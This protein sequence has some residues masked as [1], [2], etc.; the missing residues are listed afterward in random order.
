MGRSG[1]GDPI[2]LM[3]TDEFDLVCA[4]HATARDRAEKIAATMH[5]GLVEQELRL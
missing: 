2:V 3:T 5:V 1:D 4:D